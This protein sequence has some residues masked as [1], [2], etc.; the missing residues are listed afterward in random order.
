VLPVRALAPGSVTIGDAL[1][2][3]SST[4]AVAIA[5]RGVRQPAVLGITRTPSALISSKKRVPVLP[6]AC[7]RRTDTVTTPTREALTASLKTCGEG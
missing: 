5:S 1:D 3:L 2:F 7:S 4:D 6:L